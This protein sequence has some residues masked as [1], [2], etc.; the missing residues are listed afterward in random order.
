M[1]SETFLSG[2]DG[3]RSQMKCISDSRSVTALLCDVNQILLWCLLHTALSGWM[4]N[5]KLV[6]IV[7]VSYPNQAIILKEIS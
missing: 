3:L 2:A 4:V 6:L 1:C 5:F 7:S